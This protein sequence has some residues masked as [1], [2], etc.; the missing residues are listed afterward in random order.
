MSGA[1]LQATTIVGGGPVYTLSGLNVASHSQGSPDD[2]TAGWT[3]NT[4]GTIDKVQSTTTQFQTGVEWTDEQPSPSED[5]WIRATNLA[6]DNPS[7]GP[8]LGTWH[9]LAGSGAANRTWLWIET[10]NGFA[11][12]AGSLTI[13][14]STDSGGVTIVATGSYRGVASVEL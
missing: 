13:D 1:L 8:S 6:G 4:D 12:T 11:S 3:F 5:I 9:K 2:A 7:S 10:T 14:L